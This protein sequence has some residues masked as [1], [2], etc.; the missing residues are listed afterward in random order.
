MDDDR[1][2]NVIR[3]VSETLQCQVTADSA[4]DN[5]EMWDSLRHLEVIFAI[6][7][8]FSCQFSA[9]SL[10]KMNSISEITAAVRD[11]ESRI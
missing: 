10:S 1:L 5:I 7:D 4:R 3:V 6:E 9:E 2:L 8:Y 11:Y